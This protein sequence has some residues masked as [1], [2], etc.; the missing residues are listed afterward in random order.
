M[1]S[2]SFLRLL[3]ELHESGIPS[4]MQISWGDSL[5]VWL[6]FPTNHVAMGDFTVSDLS[7]DRITEEVYSMAMGEYPNSKFAKKFP[8]FAAFMEA[9]S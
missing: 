5:E 4:G 7:G 2:S 9:Q 3:T 8:T 1:M 6:G